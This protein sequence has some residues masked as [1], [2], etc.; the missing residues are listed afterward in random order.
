MKFLAQ[1]VIKESERLQR[2]FI[3]TTVL[4]DITA[5]LKLTKQNT[6][7]KRIVFSLQE[8]SMLHTQ[9]LNND[10]KSHFFINVTHVLMSVQI[11]FLE[12]FKSWL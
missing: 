12:S 8:Q 3:F 6:H 1:Q 10:N 11:L 7:R 5:N 9:E 2:N 4:L